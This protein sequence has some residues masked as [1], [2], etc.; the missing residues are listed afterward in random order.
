MSLARWSPTHKT[1]AQQRLLFL[2]LYKTLHSFKLNPYSTL[3][4]TWN[5]SSLQNYQS[6]FN[7]FFFFF[8]EGFTEELLAKTFESVPLRGSRVE[9]QRGG[10]RLTI[11]TWV[12]VVRTGTVSFH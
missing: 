11:L 1:D 7:N 10:V 5:I 12:P 6:K 8:K 2:H 3:L 4:A 9:F